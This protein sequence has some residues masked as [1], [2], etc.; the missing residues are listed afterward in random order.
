MLSNYFLGDGLTTGWL[1]VELLLAGTIVVLA[2]VRLTRLADRFA[3]D[4]RLGHAFVGMLLLATVTSLP[5]VAAGATAASIG[6][7][8][9]AF[10]AVFGSCSFNIVIIVIMN[11]ALAGGGSI[12]RAAR[13]AQLL[14]SAFGIVM[15]TIALLAIAGVE[16]FPKRPG[17][18]Q[19]V[20]LCA[21]AAIVVAYMSCMNLTHRFELRET[22]PA[23][24]T[25]AAERTPLLLPKI[26]V[27]AVITMAAAWWLTQTGDVLSEHPIAALGR[28]LGKTLIGVLFIAAATSLPEVATSVAAVRMNNLDMALG[29]V[30]GS[31]MFN[32]L[33][34]PLVKI[35]TLIKGD[36]LMM[37]GPGFSP[38][39]NMLAGLLPVLMTA[40]ALSGIVYRTQRRVFRLG[41]D[42]VLLLAIYVVGMT[43]ILTAA[44]PSG[45]SP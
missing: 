27:I 41:F 30:F 1:V 5:E 13:P 11:L 44:T 34:L 17:V 2:A 8:D 24:E 32:I 45:A 3:E 33:V 7:V 14:N 12:L 23:P 35:V 40:V 43:L 26:A 18:Q 10:G 37:A 9:I 29:N 21:C 22:P 19:I 28:P 20:E 36:T 42:S 4:W 6:A 38:T 31:N 25:A 39:T 16:K 15:I